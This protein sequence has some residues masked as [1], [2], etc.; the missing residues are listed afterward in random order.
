M[1]EITPETYRVLWE[2]G[3]EEPG[4]SGLNYEKRRGVYVCAGCGSPLF[5]SDKKYDSGS[6]WPSFFDV[7]EGGIETKVDN[8]LGMSRVEY[9]CARCG[10]HQ[11]HV[12]E[13]GPEPTG[14]R[15]CNN[16]LSLKFIPDS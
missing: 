6:G 15:Y 3:T 16:G 5:S 4:S 7:M 9:H 12:F 10:G 14:L 2:E 13:D 8:K 11:G 1:E